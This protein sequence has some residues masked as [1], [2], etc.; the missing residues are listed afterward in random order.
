MDIDT[1]APGLNTATRLAFER[2]RLAYE[3][4]M[5]AWVRTGTSLITLRLRGLQVLPVRDGGQ[6]RRRAADRRPRLSAWC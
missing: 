2:T 1:G 4:T 3:R 5:M 6:G